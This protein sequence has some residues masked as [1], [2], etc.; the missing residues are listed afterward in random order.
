MKRALANGFILPATLMLS[1]G[2]SIV[3]ATFASYIVSTSAALNSQSYNGLAQE[4]ANSGIAYAIG[5]SSSGTANW[6]PNLTPKTNCSG[7]DIS[8][9]SE[10]MTIA[11]DKSWRSTFTVA[12]PPAPGPGGSRTLLATGKVE[13][14]I[15][16]TVVTVATVTRSVTVQSSVTTI[17]AVQSA[18]EAITDL[19]VDTHACA[20]ANGKLYCWGRNTSG[21]LGLNG[22]PFAATPFQSSP[23]LVAATNPSDAFYGKT[24]TAVAV[25]TGNTCAVASSQLYCW[26]DNTYGQLGRGTVGSSDD[27]PQ[28]VGAPLAGRKITHISLSQSTPGPKSA[29]AIAD[30]ATYCWGSN[31]NQ[32]LGQT[33]GASVD[34]GTRSLPIPI[35]GYRTGDTASAPLFDKKAQSASVGTYNG[36]ATARGGMYCWGNITSASTPAPVTNITSGRYSSDPMV[37]PKSVKVI[38]RN[39]CSITS[40]PVCHGSSSAFGT[41]SPSSQVGYS[42]TTMTYDGSDNTDNPGEG[43]YC[44]V[45]ADVYCDGNSYLGNSGIPGTPTASSSTEGRLVTHVGIGPQ[46]GCIVPNGG[47]AC[48]GRSSE[49]QLANG[50]DSTNVIPRPEWVTS[51]IGVNNEM[52]G[53]F[54]RLAASGPVTVG[55]NHACALANGSFFCWGA[56]SNGQLGIKGT[57]DQLQP[58]VIDLSNF[59]KFCLPWPLNWL[60]TPINVTKEKISAGGNHTCTVAG[61]DAYCWG[62]NS[63]GQLGLNN[64]N[65][66]D[67]PTRVTSGLPG[68]VTDVSAGPRNT[69]AISEGNL[70]CWGERANN[71]IGDGNSTGSQLTPR[72]VTAFDTMQVTAVS[73]GSNHICAIANGDGYCWGSNANYAT[74]LNISTSTTSPSA[75]KLSLGLAGINSG[76]LTT[77]AFTAISAGEDYSCAIINGTVGCWGKSDVGQTGTGSTMP[78]TVPTLV[79][80]VAATLQATTISAGK[81]HACATIEGA[82]YCWGNRERGRVGKGATTGS[83]LTPLLIDGGATVGR[84]FVNIAAGGGTSCGIANALIVCWGAGT[85]G[86]IGDNSGVDQAAPSYAP[87][88]RNYD[89]PTVGYIY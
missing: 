82:S 38:G 9:L 64:T 14:I 40:M 23:R 89:E 5:C 52:L 25:G 80:G 43:R 33:V 57:V 61:G 11:K 2:L 21:Q 58:V 34:T 18:G 87:E 30:G 15:G 8:I 49:G 19:S 77:G 48:W 26:G 85:L 1:L 76:N 66:V 17:P 16:G 78:V 6:T 27:T 88:Y 12:P 35:Y 13:A 74:G 72:R 45:A 75:G 32:Q 62:D 63:Y 41:R 73:V 65:S 71:K 37:L 54:P 60:C 7:T 86:E 4:A 28:V 55:E 42:S 24:I 69:C 47:L 83:E 46:Y 10:Y 31:S 84:T 22:T 79:G 56:N 50:N 44:F 53:A 51:V 29:C 39:S 68:R 70:Y 81:T 3:S 59:P 20:I 67:I 36:C